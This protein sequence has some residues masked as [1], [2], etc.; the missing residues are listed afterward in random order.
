MKKRKEY[1]TI[2][3]LCAIIAAVLSAS[4][5][6]VLLS[7]RNTADD[8][9]ASIYQNGT[10]IYTIDLT[11]V[12]QPYTLTIE[13]KDGGENVVEVRKGEIGMISASCPDHVCVKMGFISTKAMP[14]TC[15]PNHIVIEIGNAADVQ[16]LDGVV[17]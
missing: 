5:A 11:A 7:R 1:K 12:E 8:K 9:Y 10:L 2:L 3:I 4:L 16:T 17:Y 14:I 6:A 15:L 13:G